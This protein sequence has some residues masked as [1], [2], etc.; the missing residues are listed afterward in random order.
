MILAALLALA[1][2]AGVSSVVP[3]ADLY[4]QGSR[5]AYSHL[6]VVTVI[7]LLALAYVLR[8]ALGLLRVRLR[9]RHIAYAFALLMAVSA[10]S[11]SGFVAYLFP[12][13]VAPLHFGT[14]ENKWQQLFGRYIPEW[15]HPGSRRA[16]AYFYDGLPPGAPLPW[17]AW[18][19]PLI[20]WSLFAASLILAVAG[21]ATALRR[22]WGDYEKLVFPLVQIPLAVLET[23]PGAGRRDTRLATTAYAIGMTAGKARLLM[24]SA[25]A[26]VL[27][28]HSINALHLYVPA[29]PAINVHNIPIGAALK[30][31]PWNALAAERIHILPSVI[32]VSYLLT[33][34]VAFSFWFFHWFWALQRL[35]MSAIG[36]EGAGGTSI[37]AGLYGRYQEVG[38]FFA[39]ATAALIPVIR[40]VPRDREVR[41]GIVACLAGIAGMVLWLAVA[42]MQVGWALGF[43][44]MYLVVSLV[45][46]RAVAAAGVL[47]VECSFLPQDILVRGFGYKAV[48]ARNLT[49][50]AFPEMIF[51]FEQQTILLPYMLQAYRLGEQAGIDQRWLHAGI[52]AAVLVTVPV[53][54]W[55]TMKVVY[56]HGAISLDQW[57]MVTGATWPFRRL[58]TTIAS[59]VARDW[60]AVTCAAAGAGLMSLMIWLQRNF[61]WWPIHP[62]GY[63]MGSTFTMGIM[64]FS[65][66]LGWLIKGVVEKYG[67]FRVYRTLRPAFVGLV[68]G[69]FIAAA[70]WV[71]IDGLAGQ[72][73]H[74]IFPAF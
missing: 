52:I 27:V 5:L 62:L 37:P 71:A 34:E 44:L 2:V 56:T 51:M 63:V 12:V 4:L 53:A 25:A 54:Y 6:P 26:A 1:L 29:V 11:S 23:A 7:C 72:P 49:I 3:Y 31:R 70:I 17:H 64:W 20:A 68:L 15:F 48:G 66:F 13:T 39:V 28:F 10:L 43:V 58:Q 14:P 8:P 67:G 57:H 30:A 41:A 9:L 33:S 60:A 47:F 32:G 61:L 59:Q 38:A 22:Q 50:L 40:A 35:V 46:T 19:T 36:Y 65:I 74:N 16:I 42:G 21:L 45:L 18:A 24:W 69:E 55:A 73:G